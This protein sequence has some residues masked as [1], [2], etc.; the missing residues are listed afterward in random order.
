MSDDEKKKPAPASEEFWNAVITSG[1]SGPIECEHCGL[2][3]YSYNALINRCD[4]FENETEHKKFLEE[5]ESNPDKFIYHDCDDVSFGHV[6][7]SVTPYKC[8]CNVAG[9]YERAFWSHRIL[10]CDYF[11]ERTR[12]AIDDA[13]R[14]RVVADDIETALVLLEERRAKRRADF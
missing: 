8:P 9:K 2:I 6:G 5:V 7:G 11:L 1:T 4:A 3:H 13:K 10:I 14:E 12:T